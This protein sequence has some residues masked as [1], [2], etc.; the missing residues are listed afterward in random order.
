MAFGKL[1]EVYK[2]IPAKLS[3]FA[4]SVWALS[5]IPL[6]FPKGQLTKESRTTENVTYGLR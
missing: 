4:L 6:L 1:E 2:C 5:L 3:W